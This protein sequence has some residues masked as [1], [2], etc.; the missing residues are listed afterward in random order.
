MP[1]EVRVNRVTLNQT[2]YRHIDVVR[3]ASRW[4]DR[5]PRREVSETEAEIIDNFLMFLMHQEETLFNAELRNT[6]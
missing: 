2:G 1:R 5:D 6:P 4:L 3:Y